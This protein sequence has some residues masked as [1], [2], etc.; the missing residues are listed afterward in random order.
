M[1]SSEC[2]RIK[3]KAMLIVFTGEG[4]GKT[5]AAVGQAIRALGQKKRVFMIQFIKSSGYAS[6]EDAILS[7]LSPRMHFEKGGLGFVGIMGDRL[8]LEKHKEA[9]EAALAKA[10]EAGT[11]GQYDFLILDEI[12]VA[13]HLGLLSLSEVLSFLKTVSAEVDVLFTGRDA[14]P[15]ILEL[16]ELVTEFQE[17]RHPYGV[18]HV[19]ARRGVEY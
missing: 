15:K 1:F 12:N 7:G 6:G 3:N 17:I 16:A 4:K 11:S 13:L 19:P 18:A 9:A 2:G 5:T 10:K 14:N 8:P